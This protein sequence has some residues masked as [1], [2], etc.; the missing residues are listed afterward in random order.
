[1]PC[2]GWV[3]AAGRTPS[4]AECSSDHAPVA[5]E[6]GLRLSGELFEHLGKD[7]NVS[8]V[9]FG[10]APARVMGNMARSCGGAAGG[11]PG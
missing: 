3:L 9:R 7:N 6:Y 1:M 11:P 10:D 4:C 2:V 5:A 8:F